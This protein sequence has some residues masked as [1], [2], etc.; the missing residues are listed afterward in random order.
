[1]SMLATFVEIEP[2]LIERIQGDPSVAEDLFMPD[3]PAIFDP[4][5]VRDAVLA[6]GPQLL[7]GALEMHPELRAQIEQSFGRT[8]EALRRGE[9][10]EA[11]FA[12]LQSR[13]GG[14]SG[15]GGGKMQ[16]A[17]GELSLDKAWHGVHYVLS[18]TVEPNG[19]LLGQAVLGGTET[20]EDFS[21]YGPA[22][23]FTPAHVAELAEALADPQ[24]E[25]D[26][27]GRFDPQRMRELSIYP[28]GWDEPGERGWVLH[29]LRDLRGFYAGAAAHGNAVATCLV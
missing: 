13:M 11:L 7:A 8:Q 24:V 5:K 15:G 19:S 28:F 22:R 12:L 9:G 2:G 17:H 10:G 6:R 25:Q 1:M 18:G 26:V 29:A 27:T 16:G 23:L 14:P 3:L 21:G 4:E 20:G